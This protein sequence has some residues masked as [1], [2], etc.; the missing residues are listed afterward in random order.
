MIGK[1]KYLLS[2]S[3]HVVL[4][5]ILLNSVALGEKKIF[6]SGA[7][8]SITLTG[9]TRCSKSV[10]LSSEISGKAVRVNYQIGDVIGTKP[11]VEIDPTFIKHKIKAK[12]IQ[13]KQFESRIG[14]LNSQIALLKKQYKRMLALRNDKY[15]S[16]AKY[17][18]AIQELKASELEQTILKYEKAMI[19]V[20]LNRLVDEMKRYNVRC[21]KGGIV[22]ACQVESGEF[23]QAGKPFAEI[24]DYNTLV[25]P[26]SVSERELTAL[27]SMPKT[28]N[29]KIENKPVKASINYI[30]PRFN[31]KTRK[32][33]IELK[34]SGKG[35]AKRG[36]LKFSTE[37]M[38]DTEGLLIPGSAIMNRY[39]NP[40]VKLKKSDEY[41]SVMIL[42]E[43]GG[44][45]IVTENEKLH[46]GVELVKMGSKDLR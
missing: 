44:N 37:I 41:V 16:E 12:K 9:Y 23:I 31:E 13:I 34:I 1:L 15:V 19:K 28:L 6:V 11:F 18:G 10:T 24:S 17:D 33:D 45:L 29:G 38:V 35:F 21:F 8:K 40:K 2:C 36:G 22:T 42:G 5:I 27:N 46:P 39:G 32:H 14:R 4:M 3:S 30:N 26:F 20:E 43:S 7:Q 25:V